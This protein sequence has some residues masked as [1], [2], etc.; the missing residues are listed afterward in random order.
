MVSSEV[1]HENRDK[2]DKGIVKDEGL[3]KY[4]MRRIYIL[5]GLAV[6]I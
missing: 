4:F 6:G 3:L 5:V 1:F 2:F